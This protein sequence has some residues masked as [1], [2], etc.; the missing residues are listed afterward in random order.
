[1]P[2]DRQCDVQEKKGFGEAPN[3]FFLLIMND[4]LPFLP[5]TLLRGHSRPLG[6][7][8]LSCSHSERLRWHGS[9]CGGPSQAGAP[10]D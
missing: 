2:H 7:T 10:F 9:S 8:F 5:L 6:G 4:A 1:M 3:P